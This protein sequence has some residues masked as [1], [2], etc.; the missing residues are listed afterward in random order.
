MAASFRE[1]RDRLPEDSL[2][3]IREITAVRLRRRLPH[4]HDDRPQRRITDHLVPGVRLGLL[5][6]VKK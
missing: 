2:L 1:V 6:S 3:L 4:P 5:Q